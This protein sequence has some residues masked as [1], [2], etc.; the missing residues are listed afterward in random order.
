MYQ[1]GEWLNMAIRN[2][3]RFILLLI[4]V[5]VAAALALLAVVIVVAVI[6][7]TVD[8]LKKG[9]KEKKG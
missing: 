8:A 1:T 3:G 5:M 9:K 7:A 4:L 6:K 2:T